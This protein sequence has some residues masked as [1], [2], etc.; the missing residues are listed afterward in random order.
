MTRE[1]LDK[2][3]EEARKRSEVLSQAEIDEL[4]K[5]I[6]EGNEELSTIRKSRKIKIY[7]FKRPDKFSR[8]E[9][10]NISNVSEIYAKEVKSFLAYE[11]D[12]NAKVQ[13]ASIDQLTFEEQV[14]SLP[15]P[16]PFCTFRW[17]EGAGMLSLDPALFYEGF[18]N[19]PIKKNRIPNGFEQKIFFN[20]IYKPFEK[21]LYETFSTK[22]GKSLPEITAAKYESNPIFAM[23]VCQ[24][25]EM[26]VFITFEVEIGKAEGFINLFFNA[27]FFE[28]LR[29]TNFFSTCGIANCVPLARPEPNTIVEVGR[30]RL[31]EGEGLKE[32]YVYE[33]NNLAGDPLHVYKDGKYVGDGE[34]V[35]IDDNNGVR[36]VTSP[37]Q[38]EERTEEDFY[39]TKVIF[40]GRI[41]T[42]DYKFE[43]GCIVELGEYNSEPIKIEKAGK[44]IGLGEIVVVG[45]SFGVKVTQVL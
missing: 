7:D 36:I 41:T 37:D 1:E 22:A 34:A 17:G 33:L 27:A 5:A 38:L 31:E 2:K 8:E 28:A 20:Y 42:D 13:V 11:Y 16:L 44:T 21:L 4:L 18:F 25:A 35:V 30:F 45:E 39:N 9:L 24:P 10:R 26:G 43:E 19:N 3:I 32:K 23:G 6:A 14:R 40:G 12:I 15:T 29:K